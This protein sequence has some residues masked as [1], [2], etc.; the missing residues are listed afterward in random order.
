MGSIYFL[1][2]ICWITNGAAACW[3]LADAN[4]H[5]WLLGYTSIIGGSLFHLGAML[6]VRLES[7][8]A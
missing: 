7:Q 4:A 2:A 8:V 6:Q 1:G 5:M 3:P